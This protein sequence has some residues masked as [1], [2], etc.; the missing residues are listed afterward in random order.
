VVTGIER[1]DRHPEIYPNPAAGYLWVKDGNQW[2]LEIIDSKGV[3]LYHRNIE[4]SQ[5]HIT[6]AGY[7]RGLYLIRLRKG[8]QVVNKKVFMH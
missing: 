4:Q 8:Q 2:L 1:A 5:F 6:T 3:I 7:S